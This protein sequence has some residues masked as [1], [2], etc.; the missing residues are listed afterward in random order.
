MLPTSK[1]TKKPQ[2]YEARIY[3][4]A[5]ESAKND[6]QSMVSTRFLIHVVC[7]EEE[8]Q[9]CLEVTGT[10]EVAGALSFITLKCHFKDP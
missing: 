10:S 3:P 5:E 7:M 9:N 4:A 2:P 8:M 6:S 1:H